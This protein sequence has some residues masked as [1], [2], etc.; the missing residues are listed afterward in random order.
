MY[1]LYIPAEYHDA[2]I[3]VGA[4]DNEGIAGEVVE[5]G[6]VTIYGIP[7]YKYSYGIIASEGAENFFYNITLKGYND[8]AFTQECPMSIPTYA[9]QVIDGAYNESSKDLVIKT[10]AYIR[11]ACQY[12]GTDY[13]VIDM[14]ADIPN[15]PAVTGSPMGNIPT[16]IT[17]VISS[18]NVIFGDQ[19]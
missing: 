3:A 13:S 7:Y 11:A 12:F 19:I 18:S 9:V 6:L 10:L 5:G 17:A 15:A 14:V 2:V 8:E 4:S 16:S 1:N